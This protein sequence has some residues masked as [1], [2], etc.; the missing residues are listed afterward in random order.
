MIAY[1]T[2]PGNIAQWDRE[3]DQLFYLEVFGDVSPRMTHGYTQLPP[4][5]GSQGS[6]HRTNI[7]PLFEYYWSLGYIDLDG[8][9]GPESWGGGPAM[10]RA[11]DV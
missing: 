2:W 5:E 8:E 7:A 11:L 1:A 4:P 10:P 3:R 9:C 6:A